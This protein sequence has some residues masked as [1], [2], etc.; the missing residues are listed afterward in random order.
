MKSIKKKKKKKDGFEI[1]MQ[2]A[3]T[4]VILRQ[5]QRQQA[6]ILLI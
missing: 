6:R 2:G 5:H 4:P 1:L 3:R